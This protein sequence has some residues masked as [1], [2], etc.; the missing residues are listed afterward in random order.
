MNEYLFLNPELR[1]VVGDEKAQVILNK[2]G[3]FQITVHSLYG[4]PSKAI[5]QPLGQSFLIEVYDW[6]DF[7]P[8]LSSWRVPIG[9]E[10]TDEL[11]HTE[12]VGND[13]D[14][15]YYRFDYFKKKGR[16]AD[17]QVKHHNELAEA[18]LVDAIVQIHH[19]NVDRPTLVEIYAGK[20]LSQ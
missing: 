7:E 3:R 13:E 5:L 2:L 9:D 14:F 1:E 8:S 12:P 4:T 20:R 16:S 6:N 11:S 15:S 10:D 17:D 19:R 18:G